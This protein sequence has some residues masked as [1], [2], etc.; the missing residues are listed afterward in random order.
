MTRLLCPEQILYKSL[1]YKVYIMVK[2]YL[3]QTY[4]V[5]QGNLSK[6]SSVWFCS[7]LPMSPFINTSFGSPDLL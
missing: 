7:R 4:P 2:I 6:R 3:L 5:T 1:A